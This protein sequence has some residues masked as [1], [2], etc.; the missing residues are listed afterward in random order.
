MIIK[1]QYLKWW[2]CSFFHTFS[3]NRTVINPAHFFKIIAPM[4]WFLI[5]LFH[6]CLN[7]VKLQTMHCYLI[8][9]LL[10]W[11]IWWVPNN[12]SRWQMGFNSGFKGLSGRLSISV[13]YGRRY[14]EQRMAFFPFIQFIRNIFHIA[15]LSAADPVTD[16]HLF[17]HSADTH[18]H[19]HTHTHLMNNCNGHVSVSCHIR[20]LHTW[21]EIIVQRKWRYQYN[22]WRCVVLFHKGSIFDMII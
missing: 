2:P 15:Y 6:Y 1:Q 14:T 13:Q 4:Y 11:R 20:Y 17:S 21:C 19:T 22:N 5:A 18:T 16:T 8:L 9:I 7:K 10:K 12:A 3:V